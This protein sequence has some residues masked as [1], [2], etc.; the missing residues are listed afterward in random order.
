[1]RLKI[2]KNIQYELGNSVYFIFNKIVCFASGRSVENLEFFGVAFK[3]Y[4]SQADGV[5]LNLIHF[6]EFLNKITLIS[7]ELTWEIVSNEW[8]FVRFLGRPRLAVVESYEV[9]L[10]VVR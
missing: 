8:L 7:Q 2:N 1:M 6:V 9:S 10:I 5:Y 4:S 3:F